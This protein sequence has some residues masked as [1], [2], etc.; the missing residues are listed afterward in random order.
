[1]ILSEHSCE[2]C[3]STAR[4]RFL[5]FSTPFL[6]QPYFYHTYFVIVQNLNFIITITSFLKVWPL[7]IFFHF[8]SKELVWSLPLHF[9]SSNVILFT[10]VRDLRKQLAFDRWTTENRE[11]IP[12][13]FTY[14]EVILDMMRKYREPKNIV[15]QDSMRELN[16]HNYVHKMHRLLDLEEVTRHRIIARWDFIFNQRKSCIYI[17]YKPKRISSGD[18]N[19][20][21]LSKETFRRLVDKLWEL[22][23]K[24]SSASAKPTCMF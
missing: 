12:Y 5:D 13:Q 17:C 9:S 24:K 19:M 1:M 18:T 15:T 14:D 8:V 22:F 2:Q 7:I 4:E 21:Q 3:V 23:K 10:Q 6:H 20:I 16:S 11:V